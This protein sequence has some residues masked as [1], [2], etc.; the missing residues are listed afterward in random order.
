MI[1]GMMSWACQM[2]LADSPGSVA[3]LQ[4]KKV[5]VA[6]FAQN[7]QA[8]PLVKAAQARMEEILTDHD[9]AVLDEQKTAELKDVFKTLEDPGAFVTAET[10]IEN[11]RKFDIDGLLGVYLS[12]EVVPGIADYFSA[13]AHA[14]LRFIDNQSA[15]V[16]AISTP[17]MG[18]RGVPTSDG[19]TRNSASINAVQRAVDSACSLTGFKIAEWTRAKSVE[20]VLSG[21]FPYAGERLSLPKLANDR[22]LWPLAVFAKEDWRA[23]E[24]SCTASSAGGG[25]AAIGGY[26]TDTDF[27]RRPPRLYGSRIHVVDTEARKP[28]VIFD[29]SPVEMKSREEPNTKKVLFCLFAGGWRYLCAATGNHVFMWDIEQGREISK[30]PIDSEPT[31]MMLVSNGTGSSILLQTRTGVVRYGIVRAGQ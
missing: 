18:R 22:S 24:A 3:F 21:P 4:G 29:C 14:D 27:R 9:I 8:E 12:A 26:I 17:P 30:L 25:L 11:S 23:E 15:Q 6:V 13:T 19:L 16:R 5:A 7:I 2:P 20:L 28:V 10:F 31:A 1:L